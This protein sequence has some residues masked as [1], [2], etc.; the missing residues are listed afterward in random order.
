[1]NDPLTINTFTLSDKQERAVLLFWSGFLTYSLFY[2]LTV[3]ADLDYAILQL[4]QTF[5]IGLMILGCF[6]LLRFRLES[7]YLDALFKIYCIWLLM[8]IVRGVS[9]DYEL[10]KRLMFDA[11]YGMFVFLTPLSLLFPRNLRFYR[12]AFNAVAISGLICLLLYLGFVKQ[13]LLPDFRNIESQGVVE[14]ISKTFGIPAGFIL[15]TYMY[16]S[17]SRKIVAWVVLGLTLYF[18]I[19]RARRGLSS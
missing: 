9:A 14:T 3:N 11:W 19:I 17:R 7:V 13:I 8:I 1:M 18:A 2:T 15:L 6:A 10:M 16:H 5:G 12:T 4:F